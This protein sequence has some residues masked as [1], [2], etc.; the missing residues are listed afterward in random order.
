MKKVLLTLAVTC[1]AFAA[2]A[3]LVI[4]GNLGF[5]MSNGTNTFTSAIVTPATTTTTTTDL[6]K[7]VNFYIMPK[8]G[9]NI[10][11]K[12]SAGIIL[13]YSSTSTTTINKYPDYTLVPLGTDIVRTT[14]VSTSE[15]NVTP[16][17]RY[18]VTTLNNFT[19][20]C[21]AAVPIAISPA[22]KTHYELTY[23]EAGAAKSETGDLEGAKYTS[24]GVTVTPGLNYALN[25]H[26]NMDI[27]FNAIGLGFNHRVTTTV[28]KYPNGDTDT[29][30]DAT[31]TFGLNVRTLPAGVGF[32]INYVF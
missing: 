15:I 7:T 28:T 19:F 29:D 22:Q 4:G 1:F 30:V 10:N 12:M 5:G 9:F 11:E 13:G 3:Q 14:K 17:F 23:N 16:Y 20:F 32:G 24:F 2:N 26:L 6:P 18:N 25:D 21:E 27:Y 31:N 8:I